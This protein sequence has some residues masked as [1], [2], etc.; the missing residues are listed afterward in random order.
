MSTVL[1]VW[2][3]TGKPWKITYISY[4]THGALSGG[5]GKFSYAN[6]LEKYDACAFELIQKDQLKVHIYRVVEELTPLLRRRTS[7]AYL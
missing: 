4:S 1:T 5:W 6:N 2:D 3:P 7:D